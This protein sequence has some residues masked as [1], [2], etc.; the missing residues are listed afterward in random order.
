[1][2]SPHAKARR[3]L[4]AITVSAGLFSPS[5][6][7]AQNPPP[8][9]WTAPEVSALPDDANGR[10]VRRGRDLIT[11]TYAH[12]GPEVGDP[13]KRYA[14]NN[15]ACSNC[16]LQA[17]TK[18]FGLPIFGLFELFPQYSAR[19]G[20]EI[21]IENRVNSCMLRSMNGRALPE[22]GAEMRAI[23]AYI[24][25][26]STGVPPGKILPGFGAGAI[27]EL[28]GAADPVRGKVLYVERCQSC[29]N[30]DG[31]GIRRSL[32]TTDLGYMMP[33]LWGPDSFN[34]GAGMARLITAANF[35]HS[36][37]PHGADYLNPRLTGEQSWDLA[38]FIIS[39]PRP[40]MSGLDKDFPDRANKPIDVPYGPYADGFTAQQHTYGPFGPIRKA[41]ARMKAKAVSAPRR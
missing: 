23:V 25:F 19:V 26:L 5:G 24:K 15:L 33:P 3:I 35:L 22:D 7:R 27:P 9:V 29:H 38:A 30:T 16:H 40:A 10:L 32:P 34:N 31:S 36:N 20:A 39:Q 4:L 21:S 28:K 6:A 41:L 2:L 12:I 11:A 18:K 14:G 37:M 1:M 8:A 17:G 13:A